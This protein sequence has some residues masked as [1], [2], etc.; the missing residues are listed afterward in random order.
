MSSIEGSENTMPI[1]K[2][3]EQTPRVG[4]VE[5]DCGYVYCMS[6]PTMPGI[7]KVGKTLRTPEERAK[8]LFTTG[9]ALPFKIEFAKKVTDPKGKERLLHKLLEQYHTR[10]HP[11][12]EFFRVSSEEVLGFFG[13]MDGEMW[14]DTLVTEDTEESDDEDDE[15]EE[16]VRR[17]VLGCRDMAKCFV[18][19]Q[20]I[21]HTIGINKTWIG[22]YDSFKKCVVY[23]GKAFTLN[24][25]ACNHYTTERPDRT[26]RCNA[27]KECECEVDGKWISTFS[28]RG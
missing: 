10:I 21:R 26:S 12:R 25:F 15:E 23:D 6:N 7:L 1:S 5:L 14:T 3:T 11:R 17:A 2:E 22:V 4:A 18:N 8:E 20:R 9:V 27:W 19:G 16:P 24:A 28:L 13:L